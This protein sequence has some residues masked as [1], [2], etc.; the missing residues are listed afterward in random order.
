MKSKEPLQLLQ[1]RKELVE[2]S[3]PRTTSTSEPL[4]DTVQYCILGKLPTIKLT[5]EIKI[6]KALMEAMKAE[7]RRFDFDFRKFRSFHTQF[8]ATGGVSAD[9]AKR[10]IIKSCMKNVLIRVN[11]P[12][13]ILDESLAA[14]SWHRSFQK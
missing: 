2:K 1:F 7:R 10:M 9:A 6:T 13:I 11:E 4:P 8:N 12:S 14:T 3:K 5:I